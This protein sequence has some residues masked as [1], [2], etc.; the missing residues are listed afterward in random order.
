MHPELQEHPFAPVWGFVVR[1]IPAAAAPLPKS[2]WQDLRDEISLG[3]FYF[4]PCED[5][6]SS[7]SWE[8]RMV[9][10]GEGM[11]PLLEAGAVWGQT[12]GQCPVGSGWQLLSWTTRALCLQC[13]GPH[14]QITKRKVWFFPFFPGHLWELDRSPTFPLVLP[15]PF[16]LCRVGFGH[17]Q[18]SPHHPWGA[19]S[20]FLNHGIMELLWLERPPRSALD[21]VPTN[22]CPQ[23]PHLLS[24]R[25]LPGTGPPPLLWAGVPGLDS[26]FHGDIVSNPQS[27]WRAERGRAPVG[28][29]GI[30]AEGHSWGWWI[31]GAATHPDASQREIW[32]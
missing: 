25:I 23:V 12:E 32:L 30:P 21:P 5:L 20:C 9:G 27:L 2:A 31:P 4:S 16:R 17:G 28:S 6:G 24:L 3:T 1:A 11:V 14:A 29:A 10:M 26:L 18:T 22:P 15:E 8:Q 19:L 13:P 7:T